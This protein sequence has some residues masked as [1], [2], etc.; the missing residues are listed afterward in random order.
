MDGVDH[1]EPEKNR[2]VASVVHWQW[3]ANENREPIVTS[4]GMWV[5]ESLTF[6]T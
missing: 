1:A 2:A 6:H 3:G 4:A 5:V